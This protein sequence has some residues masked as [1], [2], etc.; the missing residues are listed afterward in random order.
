MTRSDINAYSQ[1][2]ITAGGI[3]PFF[4]LE[5]G[6]DMGGSVPMRVSSWDQDVTIDGDTF[7]ADGTLISGFDHN[8]LSAAPT[9]SMPNPSNVIRD[10]I[11]AQGLKQTISIWHLWA[12]S[13]TKTVYATGD[14]V[15][16]FSGALSAV[17]KMG[18][19]AVIRC[20]QDMQ[21]KKSPKYVMSS[22]WHAA[23]GTVVYWGSNPVTVE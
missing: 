7:T 17:T 15:H 1:T 19:L 12:D 13:S 8:R 21:M 2:Q 20:R 16:L 3:K 11:V 5:I 4:A 10:L 14:R 18:V 6:W 23:A 9:I 22:P